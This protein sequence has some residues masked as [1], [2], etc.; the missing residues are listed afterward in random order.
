MFSGIVEETGEVVSF[1]PHGEG[2]RLVVRVARVGAGT[3]IGDSIAV[4]GC[5]LTVVAQTEA[6]LAFD[7][8]AETVRCTTLADRGEGSRVNLERSLRFDGKIGGHFVSGHI[9]ATAAV[10]AFAPVGADYRLEVEVPEAFRRYLVYKGS[11]ALNGVSLTVA[12]VTANGLV[13]WLI[14]HTC[15]VTNLGE[16]T[17]GA[18][19]NLECD[20]LGKYLERL[21][22]GNRPIE[23]TPDPA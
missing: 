15:E 4:D 14:P 23:R 6:T 3:E 13:V 2:R 7:V 20:L 10:K 18:R 21:L 9:D 17:A 19:I 8:L 22:P 11:V 1:A 16:L 5:C 12:E